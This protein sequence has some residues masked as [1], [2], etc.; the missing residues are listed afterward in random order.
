MNQNR[1]D[2]LIWFLAVTVCVG[3]RLARLFY[4]YAW[5]EDSAYLYHG[6][7]LHAGGHPFIDLLFVHPPGFEA[8]LSLLFGLFGVTYRVPEIVSCLVMA[9]TGI[10]LFDFVRRVLDQWSGLTAAAVFSGSCLL[11]R[12]HIFEREIYTAG[13]AVLVIWLLS[14]NHR[15]A[16]RYFLIGIASGIGLTIKL[17][18]IFISM[19]V[20]IYLLLQRRKKQSGIVFAGTMI[21][22]FGT[23]IYCF[24]RWGPPAFYQ[25]VLFHFIKGANVSFFTRISETFILDLNYVLPLGL[26]GT[27]LCAAG[28][29][30]RI[31]IVPCLHFILVTLFFLFFSATLWAH[32]MIDLLPS[33]SLGAGYALWKIRR[34]I[35][36]RQGSIWTAIFIAAT[37]LL[38]IALGAFDFKNNY[39]GWGYIPRRTVTEV[40]QLLKNHTPANQPIYAPQYLAAEAGRVRIGDYEELLGPYRWMLQTM[41]REGVRGLSRSRSFG[42]WLETV[43]KTVYLWRPEVDQAIR[44]GQPSAC[45]WDSRFPEWTMNYEID[46]IREKR[47]GLFSRAGYVVIYEKPPYLVWLHAQYLDN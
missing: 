39:Q 17:S 32:N 13:L 25:L 19:A 14:Q 46:V 45:V 16:W 30:Q 42:T 10:L 40:A 47:D 41:A 36:K 18:G 6:F 34:L 8:L 23:W 29:P 38:F 4:P 27:L 26:A 43:A 37:A 21:I 3:P 5:F 1:R 20:I 2:L 44:D 11:A 28:K 35:Q 12:Y 7:A 9:G 31:L 24:L 15:G 33:L 22:G